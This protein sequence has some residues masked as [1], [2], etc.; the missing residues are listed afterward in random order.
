MTIRV[1]PA[2]DKEGI[3]GEMTRQAEAITA[4]HKLCGN[5]R[6]LGSG[7]RTLKVRRSHRKQTPACSQVIVANAERRT[8]NRSDTTYARILG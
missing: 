8:G 1:Y 7:R 6:T 2:Y 3:D 5:A 4:I